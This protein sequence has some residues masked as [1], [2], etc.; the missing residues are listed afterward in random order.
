MYCNV[1]YCHVL[2]VVYC[3]F[4]CHVLYLTVM[5]SNVLPQVDVSAEAWTLKANVTVTV[6]PCDFTTLT[7]D[8]GQGDPPALLYVQ[9]RDA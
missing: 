1:I 9:V 2:T 6:T 3:H 8:F 7:V 5:Y 4:D